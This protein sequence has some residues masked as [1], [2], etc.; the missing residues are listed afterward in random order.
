MITSTFVAAILAVFFDTD[1]I[2]EMLSIGTLFAYLIIAFGV[3]IVRYSPTKVHAKVYSHSYLQF[4]LVV[5]YSDSPVYI[6]T[7]NIC[8]TIYGRPV[9]YILI[10]RDSNATRKAT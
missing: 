9:I 8:V 5:S 7:T 4:W 3:V 6:E 1:A 10:S 2:I